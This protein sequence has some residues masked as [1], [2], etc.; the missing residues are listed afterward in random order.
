MKNPADDTCGSDKLRSLERELEETLLRE[1]ELE[2]T[3]RAMLYLLEDVNEVNE[4]VKK[5]KK[6]IETIFDGIISPIFIHDHE[7]RVLRCNEAYR[8]AAGLPFREIVGKRYYEVF[9]KLDAPTGA[10]I[11]SMKGARARMAAE[12]LVHVAPLDR[13]YKDRSYAL[14]TKSGGFEFLH[15]MDDVTD[16]ERAK[17]K[18]RLIYELGGKIAENMDLDYRLNEICATVVSLGYSAAWIGEFDDK[19]GGMS[20]MALKTAPGA[21]SG[22]PC[23]ADPSHCPGPALEV[24][25]SGKPRVMNNLTH[26]EVNAPPSA[27]PASPVCSAAAFPIKDGERVRGVLNVCHR[28]EVFPESE[29]AFLKTFSGHASSY[30]KNA[31]LFKE[32]GEYAERVKKEM[33][34]NKNLLDLSEATAE[35]SDLESFMEKAVGCVRMLTDCDTVLSYLWDVESKVMMPNQFQGLPNA[36]VPLFATEPFDVSGASFGCDPFKENTVMV[37]R[38]GS[39]CP[40]KAGALLE[41]FKRLVPDLSTLV[42]IPLV[43]KLHNLGLLVLAYRESNPK[44]KRDILDSEKRLKLGIAHQ[45]STALE[46]ACLYRESVNQT[47]ELSHRIKT[48][49]IMHEIDKKVLST[50]QSQEIL[51]IATSM[52]SKIINCD[53]STVIIVDTE[54]KGFTFKAGVGEGFTARGRT[55]PFRFAKASEILKTH[56]PQYIP[57]LTEIKNPLLLENSLIN[58]GFMSVLRAP[59]I[60]KGDVAGVL[61]LGSRLPSA[62]DSRDLSTLEKLAS[63]IGTALEN[64]RLVGD[65]EDLFI[66]TVKALSNSIDTKSPWTMGHSERVTEIAVKMASAMGIEGEE[67]NNFKIASLLHDIG[68]LS[69]YEDILNKQGKLTEEEFALIRQHPEKGVEILEPIKPLKNIIPV[70]KYHHEFYDGRGYPEGLKGEE[71]PFLARV[72]AVA[73]TVDAMSSDRPYRK[74]K[75]MEAIIEELKRCSGTQ[76]DPQVVDVFIC[77]FC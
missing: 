18:E 24:F 77:Q 32:V 45:V 15:F 66:G 76:F 29:V 70:V 35:T 68:K 36:K 40:Q 7:M 20:A 56:S 67:L 54:K 22:C 39:S 73:D 5:S 12:E 75:P 14:E 13:I 28:G 30:I 63:H 74:G 26:K 57:D 64:A 38:K 34:L 27:L 21:A 6:D 10:C 62:F 47:M 33:A 60:V 16:V 31:L 59:V 37:I 8:R 2:E 1:A 50:L 11:K 48:I 44:S 65:L 4:A 53:R 52:I 41:F 51:E 42:L 72:L 25:N 23:L 9:P 3:R 69:T 49:E 71:I 19:K 58:E 61:C 17:E 55:V 46:E 43:G